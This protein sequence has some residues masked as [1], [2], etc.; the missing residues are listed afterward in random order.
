MRGLRAWFLRLGGLF[1]KERRDRELAEELESHLQMHIADNLRAGLTPGEA[2]RQALIKLGGL[3]QTKENYRDRRGL[4]SLESFFQD[5]R[6]GLRQLRR[7]PGF[8]AVAVLTLALGIGANTAIFTVVYAV[9]LRALPYKNAQQLVMI[10]ETAPNNPGS[11][12]P[13]AGPDFKDWQEQNKVF[14]GMAAGTIDSAAITGSGEPL[15]LSGFAVSTNVFTVLGVEPFRGRTFASDE[16]QPGHNHVVI[17]SYGLWERAFGGDPGVVGREI[18]MNGEAYAVVGIMPRSLRF[19][20]FWGRGADYWVPINFEQPAWKRERGN[21]WMWVMARMKPS[22]TLAQA[23]ADME[24]VSWRLARQ[25]PDTNA[26]VIAKVR[27][28]RDQLTG[29][30]QPALIVLFAATGFLLLIACVN[31]VNLLLARAIARQREIAVRLAVGSARWR[32]IRQLLTESVLLFVIAGG[33]G[34]AV[35]WGALRILLHAAPAGY[36]PNVAH[37]QLSPA[38]FLFAFLVAFLAGAL[39]G[40]IPAVHSSRTDLHETL[41]EG[42][43]A[44]SSPHHRSRSLL[45]AGEVALALVMLTGSGLAIRSLAR[46]LGVHAG[47]VADHVLTLQPSLPE[48]AYPKDEQIVSFYQQLLERI[49][50]LPGVVSVAATGELPLQGGSNGP[51]YIEGQPVPKNMWSSPP[52]EKI[53]VTPG[54]FRTLHI[55]MLKGR[56]FTPADT[57]KSPRVAIINA[58]MA[59]RY[60]PNEDP[61]GKRFANDFKNPQW[62]TVVG[63]VGDVRQFGLDQ[64]PIPEAYFPESQDTAPDLYLVIRT[65]TP[66]LSL[67]SAVRG[68]V[69]DLNRDLPVSG[70]RE[71]AQVVSQSSEEQ[72]FLA[73]L[74]TLLASVAL[75]LAAIGIYGVV[76]YLVAS[77][78]HEIGVRMALG[79]ERRNVL[80]LVIRQGVKLALIGVAVG[81]AGALA[82]TR[83]LASLLYEVKPTDPITFIVVSLILAGVV[84]LATYIPARRATKVDP[85][86][87]LRY[88]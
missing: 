54:F 57:D 25:Y 88:E 55:P 31:V 39:G 48:A 63:V 29:P 23:R 51:V 69:R 42:S 26:G 32:L 16:S 60:W 86:V 20:E 68:A 75:A 2:R 53:M 64:P 59:G 12:M 71:L 84:L 13:A 40:L 10:W 78:Q 66:P 46:L 44:L 52:V 38:V 87:A 74:L 9:L 4:P 28:L 8:T 11:T 85:M 35:G 37:V 62:F 73:L 14:Q 5:I 58:A 3:E 6:Y 83:F 22:V 65:A 49:R 43:R 27:G 81:V 50:A 82:L 15:K 70:V 24:T 17:L 30:I 18:T 33:A 76:A 1:H 36:I 79:A 56:D 19:P 21:H 45:T 61:L 41:K 7:S 47:F 77:R 34:L 72:R 80:W 67:L